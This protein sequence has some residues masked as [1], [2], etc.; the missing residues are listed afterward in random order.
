MT[1]EQT[2]TTD[3]AHCNQTEPRQKEMTAD[4]YLDAIFYQSLDECNVRE[5]WDLAYN[6]ND[7][8]TQYQ[9]EWKVNVAR[10]AHSFVAWILSFIGIQEMNQFELERE[11][12]A[13]KKTMRGLDYRGLWK[14]TAEYDAEF[15]LEKE[16]HWN[17]IQEIDRS[18]EWLG[19]TAKRL[20]LKLQTVEN[21]VQKS[22]AKGKENAM[23]AVE[24]IR[25]EIKPL[26]DAWSKPRHRFPW[27]ENHQDEIKLFDNEYFT[28]YCRK[29]YINFLQMNSV[30]LDEKFLRK[31][32]NHFANHTQA[33][34][35]GPVFQKAANRV[36]AQ[37]MLQ[38]DSEK[39][40]ND[41]ANPYRPPDKITPMGT[42]VWYNS[43]GEIHRDGDL[44]AII[45][46][47]GSKQYFKNGKMHRDNGKPAY[48]RADGYRAWCEND[49]FIRGG[50]GEMVNESK[51]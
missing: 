25:E 29:I 14:L 21:F 46:E 26:A 28:Q 33:K 48:E 17:H 6:E 16:K 31:I 38:E 47:N 23:G 12:A 15:A 13:L 22:R 7:D 4:D 5:G 45:A 36:K 32:G 8:A 42:Q 27:N 39:E 30:E 19:E 49:R 43:K 35:L 34:D 2:T 44:P 41:K 11:N 50:Y 51:G 18:H 24:E 9:S 40:G 1:N 3:D 37:E 20:L 10:I